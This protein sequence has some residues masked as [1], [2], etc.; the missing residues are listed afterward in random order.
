M[1]VVRVAPLQLRGEVRIRRCHLR[2][3]LGPALEHLERRVDRRVPHRGAR[4]LDGE[5]RER[6]GGRSPEAER[7]GLRL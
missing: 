6:G 7:V 5:V 3:D 2:E 4:E 1:V